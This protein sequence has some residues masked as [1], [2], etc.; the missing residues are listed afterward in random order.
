VNIFNDEDDFLRKLSENSS[1]FNYF[2]NLF[3]K[4]FLKYDRSKFRL[5]VN[6]LLEDLLVKGLSPTSD[7]YKMTNEFYKELIKKK[8][9]DNK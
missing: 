9:P 5:K 8:Y 2:K 6:Q 3:H 7:E 4:A 1:A